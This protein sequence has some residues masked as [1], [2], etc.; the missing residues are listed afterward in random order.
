MMHPG[1]RLVAERVATELADG[2]CATA[3][4]PPEVQLA[5]AVVA[6]PA[7]ELDPQG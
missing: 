2:R 7:A 4:P 1:A 5:V 3:G 6:R